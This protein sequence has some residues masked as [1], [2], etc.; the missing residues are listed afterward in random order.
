MRTGAKN[1][2]TNNVEV[3]LNC[4]LSAVGLLQDVRPP[5]VFKGPKTGA[6]HAAEFIDYCSKCSGAWTRVG[7]EWSLWRQAYLFKQHEKFQTAEKS[8]GW[9][10]FGRKFDGIDRSDSNFHLKKL[11]APLS[12]EKNGFEQFF[13]RVAV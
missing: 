9:L 6:P 13:A 8:R 5:V 1:I 3:V 11:L 12:F 4:T 2:P 10:L 7:E